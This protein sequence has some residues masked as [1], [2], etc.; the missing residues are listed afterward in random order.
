[1]LVNCWAFVKLVRLHR[2]ALRQPFRANRVI[3]LL[4]AACLA[5]E[6]RYILPR[7]IDGISIRD[8]RVGASWPGVLRVSLILT[9][10]TR[11]LKQ[12]PIVLLVEPH[13]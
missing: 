3:I 6:H 10:H 13:G 2:L 8:R 5:L 4:K 1:M 9:Q 11:V 12:K 7:L